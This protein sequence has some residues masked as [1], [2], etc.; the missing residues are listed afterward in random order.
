M[1]DGPR[2]GR[3]GKPCGRRRK[4]PR[5]VREVGRRKR[6]GVRGR[7]IDAGERKTMP[8]G[9]LKTECRMGVGY[10]LKIFGMESETSPSGLGHEVLLA[11]QVSEGLAGLD[12]AEEGGG[13]APS[14]RKP[15]RR[16][17][18]EGGWEMTY[19]GD[20]LNQTNGR[21]MS[22]CGPHTPRRRTLLQKGRVFSFGPF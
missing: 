5:K 15:K 19:V 13:G 21:G 2:P 6:P 4:R 17:S 1:G 10:P 11:S 9:G 12:V 20:T 18:G 8:S 3:Q 16:G 22:S 14:L 7:G